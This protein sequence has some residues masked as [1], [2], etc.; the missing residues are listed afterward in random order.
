[1]V[2]QVGIHGLDRNE[3]AGEFGYLVED[4]HFTQNS[5]NLR[6]KAPRRTL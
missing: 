1:V 4:R 2:Y 5:D 6:P 3:I